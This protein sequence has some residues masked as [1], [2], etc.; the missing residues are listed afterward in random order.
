MLSVLNRNCI[1]ERIAKGSVRVSGILDNKPRKI[2][3]QIHVIS[4]SFSTVLDFLK[5]K[6]GLFSFS[7]PSFYTHTHTHANTQ[8]YEYIYT[9]VEYQKYE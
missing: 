1:N 2:V 4:S 6:F 7:Y 3:Q 9:H 5:Y 8:I